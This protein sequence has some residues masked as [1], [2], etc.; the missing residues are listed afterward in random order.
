MVQ[1][2]SVNASIYKFESLKKFAKL[3]KYMVENEID[4]DE[5][6][7]RKMFD[8][9]K[10]EDNIVNNVQCDCSSIINYISLGLHVLQL[11]YIVYKIHQKVQ[12]KK[13]LERRVNNAI[14]Q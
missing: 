11:I 7:L 5:E 2:S 6:N 14:G 10:V 3:L 12:K 8:S 1:S 9:K 4:F 13:Y